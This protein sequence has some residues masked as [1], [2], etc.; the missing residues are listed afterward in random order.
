MTLTEK[1]HPGRFPGMSPKMAAI[2]GYIL[3]ETFTRPALV[4]LSVTSDGFVLGRTEGDCGLNEWI[5]SASDL[6]RNWSELLAVADLT[7][8][9]AN[10]ARAMYTLRLTDWRR[11]PDFTTDS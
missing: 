5:G 8:A 11:V 4:E 7:E 6:E 9:E 3:G 10:V 2:V 1:L